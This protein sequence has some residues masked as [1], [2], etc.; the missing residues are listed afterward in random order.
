[1]LN[2]SLETA[3]QP[4]EVIDKAVAF[5]GKGG[6]GLSVLE[7]GPYG[8]YLEGGGGYVSIDI[9]RS[10]TGNSVTLETREWEAQVEEF[11]GQ[12]H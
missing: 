11:A 12:L 4:K 5:F 6:L 9:R 2:L 7:R 10:K 3:L 1:M 8:V